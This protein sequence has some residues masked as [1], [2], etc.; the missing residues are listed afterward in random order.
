MSHLEWANHGARMRWTNT[1]RFILIIQ[2][3]KT[4][5]SV[6]STHVNFPPI[7]METRKRKR[8]EKETIRKTKCDMEKDITTAKTT[9]QLLSVCI[10]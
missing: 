6:Y 4:I 10:K 9:S 8:E 7:K 3:I 2:P 1:K 5:F